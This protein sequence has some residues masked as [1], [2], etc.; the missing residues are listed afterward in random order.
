MATTAQ[1]QIN[2]IRTL[3]RDWPLVD[4]LTAAITTA[5]QTTATV[6]DATIYGTNWVVQID[7]EAMIVGSAVTST[8]AWRQRGARGTTAATHLNGAQVLLRPGFLDS[9][10][11]DAFN[12]GIDACYPYI[13]QEVVDTSLTVTSTAYEYTVPQVNA[14]YI[15]RIWKIE[16]QTPGD[17]AYR[18]VEDWRIVRGATPKIKFREI[19]Y[20]GATLRVT[21][22]APFAHLAAGDSMSA[23]WP[24]TADFLPGLYA[25]SQ[26]LA[27]GEAGRVRQS[28]GAV[29]TRE[30]ANRT[31]SS[32]A[33]G[34][35]LYQRFKDQLLNGGHL[36]PIQGHI[37]TTY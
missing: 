32:S 22:Y 23:Q 21:G 11:L 35:D 7:Q 36:P 28:S 3:L 17:T 29:D 25:A 20:P 9:E 10:I 15:P 26:L 13:Y 19:P 33:A 8:V 24:G 27:S 2:R 4:V 30:Q 14:A 5:G 37:V 31:G 34:R 1:T 6:A 12:T 18:K 16:T